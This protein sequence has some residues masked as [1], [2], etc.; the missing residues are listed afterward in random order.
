VAFTSASEVSIGEGGMACDSG[1]RQ[2]M[3]AVKQ[4]PGHLVMHE[5][6]VA[7]ELLDDVKERVPADS[8]AH[9]YMHMDFSIVAIAIA[10]AIR[11]V[12]HRCGCHT[13]V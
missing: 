13:R 7:D 2:W 9:R 8:S 4:V 6:N 3:Q 11:V 1:I 10:I 12:L 5:K